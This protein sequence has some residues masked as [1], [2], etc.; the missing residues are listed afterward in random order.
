VVDK[1]AA[2]GSPIQNQ[3]TIIELRGILGS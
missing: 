3:L 2:P 1:G